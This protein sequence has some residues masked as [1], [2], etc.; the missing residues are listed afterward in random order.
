MEAYISSNS[1]FCGEDPKPLNP[2]LTYQNLLFC[3]VP[4]N[5]ILGL[6]MGTYKKVGYGS[7]VCSRSQTMGGHAGPRCRESGGCF[8]AAEFGPTLPIGF[9]VGVEGFEGLGLR[10]WG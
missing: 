3:R 10:V 6:I 8:L 2:I 7:K 9:R 5:F 1:K 4:I